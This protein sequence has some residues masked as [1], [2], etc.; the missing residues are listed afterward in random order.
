MRPTRLLILSTA[1][2]AFSAFGPAYA[3]T[4]TNTGQQNLPAE[5]QHVMNRERPDR[6]EARIQELHDKLHV[7]G[8]QESNWKD[9]AE[10]MR[11]TAHEYRETVEKQADKAKTGPLTAVDELRDSEQLAQAH[12]DGIKRIRD[13]F[14]TLYKTMGPDQQKNAD[15]L[16]AEP[17]AERN[18]G[19]AGSGRSMS[20]GGSSR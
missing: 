7:T 1:A 8:D 14:E 11:R 19:E 2:F 20:N 15:E 3:A 9:V 12:V 4:T 10:A 13:P 5:E 16:F 18:T 6:V 17:P